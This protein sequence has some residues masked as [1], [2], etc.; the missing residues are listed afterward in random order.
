VSCLGGLCLAADHPGKYRILGLAC[1]ACF[2]GVAGQ[3]KAK[4]SEMRP[5]PFALCLAVC[6][7]CGAVVGA[8]AGKPV[9]GVTTGLAAGAAIASVL[10][11]L[12]KT[13]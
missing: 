1:C 6:A 9:S 13:T 8:V 4:V 10:I 11:L 12:G 2:E 7:L 3:A 5:L